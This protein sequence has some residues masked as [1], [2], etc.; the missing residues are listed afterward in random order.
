MEWLKITLGAL[1]GLK[2]VKWEDTLHL[3][4]WNKESV[5]L[6]AD[7]MSALEKDPEELNR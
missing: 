3:Q 4:R 1:Q 2:T 6:S 5:H 7:N